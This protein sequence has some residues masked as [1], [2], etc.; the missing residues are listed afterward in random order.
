MSGHEPFP[1]IHPLQK[2]KKKKKEHGS[3]YKEMK[4][5]QRLIIKYSTN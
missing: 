2:K 1:R 4:L 5:T 3:S